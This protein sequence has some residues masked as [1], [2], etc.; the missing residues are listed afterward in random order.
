M[1]LAWIPFIHPLN[2]FHDWWFMLLLPLALGIAMIYKGVRMQSLERFWR[3]TL[4]LA[5]QIVLGMVGL[6]VFVT[7]L[8]Q[9]LIPLLPVE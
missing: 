9:V 5:S 7:I 8:V 1:T 3:E 4:I 6:A 2:V